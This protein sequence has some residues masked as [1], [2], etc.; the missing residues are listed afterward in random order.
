MNMFKITYK[1]FYR[2]IFDALTQCQEQD[3]QLIAIDS[4]D[5]L[6]EIRQELLLQGT[7]GHDQFFVGLFNFEP[8]EKRRRSLEFETLLTT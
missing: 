1:I 5:K 4:C 2:N 3:G 8:N 7:S 6:D